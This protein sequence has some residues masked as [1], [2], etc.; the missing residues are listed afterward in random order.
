VS[1]LDVGLLPFRSRE[2][3]RI[4]IHQSDQNNFRSVL[5]EV[6][7]WKPLPGFLPSARLAVVVGEPSEPGPYVIRVELS[8]GV[9]LMP[10]HPP[11]GRVYTDISG[12]LY[13]GLGSQS[14]KDDCRPTRQR[15]PCAL[16]RY[17]PLPLRQVRNLRHSGDGYRTTGS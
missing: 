2:V 17:A 7:D 6:V 11:E 5:R 10:H 12:V 13:V 14:T 16:R 15:R 9:K 1:C 8:A 3:P 4:E